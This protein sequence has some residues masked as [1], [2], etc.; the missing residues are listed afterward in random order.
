[1]RRDN[2]MFI[3]EDT[4]PLK[5]FM[6]DGFSLGRAFGMQRS[7]YEHAA[8]QFRACTD[9]GIIVSDFSILAHQALY[10]ASLQNAGLIGVEE[11]R[12]LA[13]TFD[14]LEKQL[15]PLA[16]IIYCRA[17]IPTVKQR[18][19]ARG[20]QFEAPRESYLAELEE[21]AEEL[22][23]SSVCP[24]LR[25]DTRLVEPPIREFEQFILEIEELVS[26]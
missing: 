10:T 3:Y 6:I 22:V 26:P 2:V 8:R 18:V 25:V 13:M 19:V 4:T 24:V 23:R 9:D 1:M 14:R 5:D 12:E 21:R 7:F 16:G 17:D 20:R 11:S 15:P